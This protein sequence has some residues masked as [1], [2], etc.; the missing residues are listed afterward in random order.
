MILIQVK[1]FKHNKMSSL[2]NAAK[3]DNSDSFMDWIFKKLFDDK[4]LTFE[5]NNLT[6]LKIASDNVTHSFEYNRESKPTSGQSPAS[7]WPFQ[8]YGHIDGMS[9]VCQDMITAQDMAFGPYDEDH[10]VKF[11]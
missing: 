10:Y 11:F 3:A 1:F 4:V 9:S 6:I 5:M 7:D 2:C 8:G